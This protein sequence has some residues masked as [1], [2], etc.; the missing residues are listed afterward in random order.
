MQSFD[1]ETIFEFEKSFAQIG[2]NEKIDS[3]S[4]ENYSDQENLLVVIKESGEVAVMSKNIHKLMV[5]YYNS[6]KAAQEEESSSEDEEEL[7]RIAAIEAE[8]K[9][10]FYRMTKI[11]R[12]REE[13]LVP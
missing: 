13:P 7:A 8:R 2:V 11:C 5:E 3:I 9:K 10:L 12:G 1:I 6:I 4:L